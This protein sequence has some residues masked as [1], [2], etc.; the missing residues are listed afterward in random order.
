MTI[1]G[2]LQLPEYRDYISVEIRQTSLDHYVR[3]FVLSGYFLQQKL[4]K[5]EVLE[6]KRPLKSN[7][8]RQSI[9]C[10]RSSTMYYK[11]IILFRLFFIKE[12]CNK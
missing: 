6:C 3:H 8:R 1:F 4:T 5:E 9:L 2:S 12:G 11:R 10:R 7:Q